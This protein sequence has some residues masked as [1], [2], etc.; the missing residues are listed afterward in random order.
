MWNASIAYQFL[1][2]RQATVTLSAYDLLQQRSNIYRSITANYIDDTQY[3]S[4]TRYFM[5]SF[6]YKFNTF[7]KGEGP[8]DTDHWDRGPRGGHPGPP[9]GGRRRF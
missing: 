7:A 2:G 1:R 5:A 3:N 9:P 4:L 6:S 8:S